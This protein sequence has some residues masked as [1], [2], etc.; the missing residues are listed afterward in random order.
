MYVVQ[1]TVFNDHLLYV[2]TG[3]MYHNIMVQNFDCKNGSRKL[4]V[5]TMPK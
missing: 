1:S 2:H 3:I 5:H 4:A